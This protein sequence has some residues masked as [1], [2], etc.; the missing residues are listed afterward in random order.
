MK[1]TFLIMLGIGMATALATSAHAG[2]PGKLGN[3]VSPDGRFGIHVEKTEDTDGITMNRVDLVELKSGATLCE[4]DTVGNQWA[5]GIRVL[6]SPDSRRL[7]FVA[8]SRRGDWTDIWVL[9]N[10][11]FEKVGLPEMP[12]LD[13]NRDHYAKTVLA[14]YS[15]VRWAKLDVLLLDNMAEDDEGNSARMRVALHVDADN[16]VTVTRVDGKKR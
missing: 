15:A 13:M 14:S 16:H 6:W 1:H 8:P 12:S 11:S 9:K 4:L 2:K 5:A 10:G 7:A 3:F